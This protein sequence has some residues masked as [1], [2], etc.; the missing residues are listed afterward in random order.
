MKYRA[1][2][3]M[4][5]IIAGVILV[6]S[7]FLSVSAA[8]DADGVA[9]LDTGYN[10][11][12]RMRYISRDEGDEDWI[13]S[14]HL[15]AIRTAYSLPEG[16][17][18]TEDNT[19]SAA[20]SAYP[21]YIF[22]ENEGE[23]GIMYFYTE[24]G[25]IRMNPDSSRMFAGHYDLTDISG[26]QDW[27]ASGVTTM[28][29]MF[30]KNRSLPDALALRNWD[31]SNVTNM[32]YMFSGAS[33]L[34]YIDVSG[35]NTGK[36]TTMD[37]MF[38]VGSSFQ[39]NGLL[40]EILGIG[41]LDV[42]GVTDMTCMFYGAGKMT[43][44]DI[45]G[46]DVSRVVSMN[47]MFCDNQSLRELDLSKWDVSSLKTVHCMFDDNFSLKTIGDV[48]HWNTASLIDAGGWLNYATSF[49][50]DDNGRLD[51]SGWDTRNLKAA[52]EMFLY[53]QLREIDLSGWSFDAVTN[54]G[55]EGAGTGIYYE[56]G[57]DYEAL[58]GFGQ[59]FAHTAFLTEVTVS[60]EGLDSFS[61]AVANGANTVDMW[62]ESNC[63][64]FTV[65]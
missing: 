25:T 19:V 46:W 56:Y 9:L 45:G 18:P 36:V 59:M 50:G 6:C 13:N 24:A 26:L 61:T 44:Y 21:I 8:E 62:T 39:G 20:E 64:G 48:S 33:S 60:K 42:S 58:R 23:A 51:L 16:F 55:W 43:R 29:A 37:S 15:K 4:A 34:M 35:W 47:H 32:A 57:N 14:T 30:S 38:Q 49:I 12:V 28:Y 54:E 22:F 17:V 40:R 63:K 52:G 5:W 10:V 7:A 65:K 27:D 2:R 3:R 53:T 41:N 11:N 31:T 1:V